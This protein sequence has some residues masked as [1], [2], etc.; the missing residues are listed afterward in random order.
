[1]LDPSSY[2][3]LT[4]HK[5]FL[6]HLVWDS[7][8]DKAR[9][10]RDE[11]L[12]QGEIRYTGFWRTRPGHVFMGSPKYLRK[13]FADR[14]KA[15]WD[16]WCINTAKLDRR[17]LNPDEDHFL[18]QIVSTGDHVEDFSGHNFIGDKHVCQYF[19]RQFPPSKWAYE[20][21]EYLKLAPLPSIGE[22]AD[23]IG[24]G[25]N[26]AETRYSITKE[27]LAYDG[28]VPPDALSLVKTTR[29]RT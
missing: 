24:L 7:D 4:A 19:G 25:E 5:P 2:A 20:W 6:F 13:L 3:E 22:W 21:A 11:G 16:L 15:P 1:M 28:T 27:S 14:D 17:K 18:T 12:M 29:P 9:S 8:E 26:P 10:V 23:A